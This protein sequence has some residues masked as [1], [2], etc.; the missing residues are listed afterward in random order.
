MYAQVR[1]QIMYV[2]KC[3]FS[4][5]IWAPPWATQSPHRKSTSICS[6]GFAG[7]TLVTKRQTDKPRYMCNNRPHVMLRIAIRPEM[8]R[9][10]LSINS[11]LR[12]EANS[13]RHTRHDTDRTVLSCLVVACE[14]SRP[15]RPTSAFCAGVRPA[16]A[17]QYL[18][19]PTLFTSPHQTRHKQGTVLS[20]LAG[21]VNW[22]L[23]NTGRMP[24]CKLYRQTLAY[25][26]VVFNIDVIYQHAL[27][28][29]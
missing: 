6:T 29:S 21:G 19:H 10:S 5:V 26:R 27:R 12:I 3:P 24:T 4:W 11:I 23:R 18:R 20:Y 7:L 9:Q 28:T 2:C 16:V 17:P 13:H 22:A 15:D 1:P 25:I 8:H 14:M